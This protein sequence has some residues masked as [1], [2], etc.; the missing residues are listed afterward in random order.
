MS[1]PLCKVPVWT[2]GFCPLHL[3][4]LPSYYAGIYNCLK[5]TSEQVL[6]FYNPLQPYP[7]NL[8]N[9]NTHQTRNAHVLWCEASGNL[10]CLL[11]RLPFCYGE[12]LCTDIP[13]VK[14]NWPCIYE[15]SGWERGGW[16]GGTPML[17]SAV[18]AT[19]AYT[20]NFAALKTKICSYNRDADGIS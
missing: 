7:I 9:N 1:M 19:P 5:S 11:I 10:T 13:I 18:G 3:M 2:K 16:A 6:P 12:Y 8:I 4:F 14:K 15:M 17:K 20:A